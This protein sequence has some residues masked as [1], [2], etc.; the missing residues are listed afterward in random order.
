MLRR[1]VWFL[2]GTAAGM[3]GSAWVMA[4]VVRAR[5]AVTP[6]SLRRFAILSVADV[7]EGAGTR[8]RSPNGRG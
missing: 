2:I 5:E 4:R 8:L 7:L 6:A 1:V 3:G